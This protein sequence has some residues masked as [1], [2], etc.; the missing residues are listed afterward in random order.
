[1]GRET[2]VGIAT[3]YWLNGPVI[4]SQW[5]GG[6]DFP[7]PS[8]PALGPTQ[9]PIRWGG[10]SMIHRSSVVVTDLCPIVWRSEVEK[11]VSTPWHAVAKWKISLHRMACRSEVEKLMFGP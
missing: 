4:E 7:H 5:E 9:P 6:R 8:R 11:S 1:V 10:L 2:S 3:R